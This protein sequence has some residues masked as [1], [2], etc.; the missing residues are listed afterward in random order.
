LTRE[1]RSRE[2]LAASKQMASPM[3]FGVLIITIVYLP[4]LTLTGIEG[5]MFRPMAVTV[6]FALAAPCC[7]RSRSMPA[8]CSLLPRRKHRR[9]GKFHHRGLNK[10]LPA[11][12]AP[13]DEAPLARRALLPSVSSSSAA[14]KF[15]TLG[16]RSSCRNSM[17]AASSGMIYRKVGMN[18]KESLHEDLELGKWC[19]RSSP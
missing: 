11:A 14:A 8:M 6:I 2:V 1:E 7:S 12:A 5:K 10:H 16:C 19:A 3:F 18:L 15:T 13:R 17:K 9:E 4:I